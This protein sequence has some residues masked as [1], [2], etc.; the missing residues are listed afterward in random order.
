MLPEHVHGKTYYIAD[1]TCLEK[2]NT[3]MA[4]NTYLQQNNEN[5]NRIC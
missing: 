3:N 1:N 2:K 4:N 5:V